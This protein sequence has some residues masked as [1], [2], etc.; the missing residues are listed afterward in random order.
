MP[1]VKWYAG[2]AGTITIGTTPTASG[3]ANRLLRNTG[4]VVGN[5][6]LSDDATNVSL[7]SGQYL[8][9]TDTGIRRDAAGSVSF[10]DGSTGHATG[11]ALGTTTPLRPVGTTFDFGIAIQATGTGR[12]ALI[13]AGT[14][15]GSVNLVDTNATANARWVNL[16]SSAD[17]MNLRRITDDG[18]SAVNYLTANLAT[19][20]VTLGSAS[21]AGITLNPGTGELTT[22]AGASLNIGNAAT[23]PAS[24]YLV[25]GGVS[26]AGGTPTES[27]VTAGS[28]V[29]VYTQEAHDAAATKLVFAYNLGGSMRYLVATL[30]G[31]TTTLTNSATRP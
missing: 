11:F 13:A 21:V 8:L 28:G 30:D 5:S 10:S 26:G 16:E 31:T 12:A 25:I 20:A 14:L 3:T 18:A 2:A 29:V 23:A 4:T 17:A 27:H 15:T 9:S 19:D 24:N 22:T 7:T 6:L 1:D